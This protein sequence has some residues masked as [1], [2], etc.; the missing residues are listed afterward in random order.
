MED[1]QIFTGAQGIEGIVDPTEV[2]PGELMGSA[3]FVKVD[4]ETTLIVGGRG[5][6]KKVEA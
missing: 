6:E 1:I 2:E 5:K 3:E 4:S